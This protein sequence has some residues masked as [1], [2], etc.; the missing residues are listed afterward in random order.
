M[1][2]NYD[3]DHFLRK[4]TTAGDLWP[5]TAMH[6]ILSIP[7]CPPILWIFLIAC[8][9]APGNIF[10][11][12]PS[13]QLT[14]SGISKTMAC[15]DNS[16]YPVKSPNWLSLLYGSTN[17][18]ESTNINNL[19]G[20]PLTVFCMCNIPHLVPRSKRVLIYLKQVENISTSGGTFFYLCYREINTKYQNYYRYLVAISNSIISFISKLHQQY[21]N[22][23]ND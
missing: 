20:N 11:S 21:I 10:V 15:L 6:P 8:L 13:L 14:N 1:V 18:R 4:S 19:G 2:F 9:L 23:I 7:N 5:L 22:Y 17:A 3:Y 12:L 16:S